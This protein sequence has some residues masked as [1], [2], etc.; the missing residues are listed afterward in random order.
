MSEE[1]MLSKLAE[2]K[3]GDKTDQHYDAWAK[4]YE[5]DLLH[6]VGYSAHIIG[7][8]AF[9]N[10]G[11]AKDARIVDIG[12]GTGL[13]GAELQRLGFLDIDGIDIST[14]M[15][16]LCAEKA[17]YENLII[18][19]M[20]AGVSVGDASYDA[21]IC[22]GS[23]A[24]GHL[25]PLCLPEIIRLVK[26]GAPI[27]IFMNAAPFLA[28]NYEAHIRELETSGHWNVHTIE[29]M[30]YMSALDRPGRLIV[31]KKAK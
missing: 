23:F 8:E 7:A 1:T 2:F 6:T 17:I 16:A 4:T 9:A 19:D 18:G 12:C 3:P 10:L 22:I 13:V 14:E 26:P 24:P 20:N 25:S 31:A 21:A 5:Q 15:L 27:V 29:A 30:N 28:E 11:L